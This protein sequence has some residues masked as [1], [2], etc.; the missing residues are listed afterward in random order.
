MTPAEV[1]AMRD[2]LN[3]A[4]YAVFKDGSFR[5]HNDSQ[6]LADWLIESGWVTGEP[7]ENVLDCKREEENK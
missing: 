3:E 2:K 6:E 5:M 7:K 4:I 1:I